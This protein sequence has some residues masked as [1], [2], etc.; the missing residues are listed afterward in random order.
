MLEEAEEAVLMDE[1]NTEVDL[2]LRHLGLGQD[3]HVLGQTDRIDLWLDDHG[4]VRDDHV[5]VLK[6]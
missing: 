5:L 1:T 3:D 4:L 6:Q 2:E